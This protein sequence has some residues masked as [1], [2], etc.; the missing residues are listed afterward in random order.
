VSLPVTVTPLQGFSGTVQL[1]AAG[2]NG[3]TA[4]TLVDRA[5]ISVELQWVYSGDGGRHMQ[6]SFSAAPAVTARPGLY[7]Q[8]RQSA[9]P[10]AE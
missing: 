1:A 6:Y 8:P 3:I 5:L 2:S 4:D 7:R 10:V 9:Q